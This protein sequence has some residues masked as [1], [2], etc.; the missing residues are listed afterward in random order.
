M[1]LYDR[2]RAPN[3]RRVR[4]VMAE[5]GIEDVEIVEVDLGAGEHKTPEYLAEVGVPNVPALVLDDG[6]AIT[7]SVAI[8]RYLE[9]VYPEPNLYGRD[10]VEIGLIEMWTRRVELGLAMPLMMAAR[11]GDPRLAFLEKNQC[12]QTAAWNR[13]AALRSINAFDRRL[14]GSEFIAGSRITIADICAFTAQDF[15]RLIKFEPPANRPHFLR[16]ATAMRE[17]PAARAGM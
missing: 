5:K 17:R 1:K 4:W 6:V 16:W 7:E 12:P 11:L 3:P 8:G 9:S 13:E 15:A 2:L 14:E 10:A